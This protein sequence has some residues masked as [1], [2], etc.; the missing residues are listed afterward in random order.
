L[1]RG[2]AVAAGLVTFMASTVNGFASSMPKHH[3]VAKEIDLNGT[4]LSAPVGFTYNNTAYIPIWY[5]MQALADLGISSHWDGQNWALT[6]PTLEKPDLTNIETGT[7]PITISINGKTIKRVV[8]IADVDPFSKTGTMFMPVWYVMD[9]LQR[10]NVAS[11][12]D[13]TKWD[14]ATDMNTTVYQPEDVVSL[15]DSTASNL[16]AD[17]DL[18]VLDESLAGYGYVTQNFLDE[19]RQL[20]NLIGSWSSYTAQNKISG[21]SQNSFDIVKKG[22]VSATEV[23]L[24]TTETDTITYSDSTTKE[25][26]QTIDWVVVKNGA[27]LWQVDGFSPADNGQDAS[28]STTADSSTATNSPTSGSN[29]TASSS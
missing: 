1:K 25:E 22:E 21:E 15:V 2:I 9:I 7:G 26:N 24:E 13:G 14:I 19:D 11:N 10:V 5:V 16:S 29:T 3:M 8:G 12:W 27:G 23:V 20:L 4:K 17:D 18:T 28:G 6:T